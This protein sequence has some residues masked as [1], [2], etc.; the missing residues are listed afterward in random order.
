MPREHYQVLTHDVYLS[1]LRAATSYAI[2]CTRTHV[3]LDKEAVGARL[4]IFIET[5]NKGCSSDRYYLLHFLFTKC[6]YDLIAVKGYCDVFQTKR[7]RC[8]IKHG[9]LP[10]EKLGQVKH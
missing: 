7:S 3:R 2:S 10:V 4:F 6:R 5:S 8:Y 9:V 1:W